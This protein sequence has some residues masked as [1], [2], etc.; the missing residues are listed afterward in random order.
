[1]WLYIFAFALLLFGIVGGVLS[2]GIFT[3]VL[4]PLGLIA[5][6]TALVMSRLAQ[7]TGAAQPRSRAGTS[8]PA[9][10]PHSDP[11]PSAAAAPST[12]DEL[13]DARRRQQ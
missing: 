10:L 3:V 11:A 1:M 12:P 6:V 9:P 13:V 7:R 8:E 2:G 4:V 5:L